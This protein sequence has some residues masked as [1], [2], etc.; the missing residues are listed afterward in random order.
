MYADDTF[1]NFITQSKILYVLFAVIMLVMLGSTGMA[2]AQ[3]EG[4][5]TIQTYDHHCTGAFLKSSAISYALI[6]DDKPYH[7]YFNST[8][9][10]ECESCKIIVIDFPDYESYNNLSPAL[11]ERTEV[12]GVGDFQ[13]FAL[14]PYDV[15]WVT[16]EHAQKPMAGEPG[17]YSQLDVILNN[18]VRNVMGNLDNDSIPA[19]YDHAHPDDLVGV[20]INTYEPARVQEYLEQN[21]AVSLSATASLDEPTRMEAFVPVSL[22][23]SFVEQ[24]PDVDVSAMMDRHAIIHTGDWYYDLD[25]RSVWRTDVDR[26]NWYTVRGGNVGVIDTGADS[27]LA[28]DELS[29]D[30]QDRC[31]YSNGLDP[32]DEKPCEGN[33]GSRTVEILADSNPRIK[34]YVVETNPPHIDSTV[35]WMFDKGV[36]TIHI[37]TDTDTLTVT[38]S[39]AYLLSPPES[40]PPSN[41][42]PIL[43]ID[44][45][46]ISQGDRVRHWFSVQD[47]DLDDRLFF[48]AKSSNRSIASI[49]GQS[50]LVADQPPYYNNVIRSGY[51]DIAPHST[52]MTKITI[53]VSDGAS[54]VTDTFNVIVTNNTSPELKIDRLRFDLM[55]GE[56][57]DFTPVAVDPDGNTLSYEVVEPAGGFGFVSVSMSNDTVTLTPIAEGQGQIEITASDGKGGYDQGSFRVCVVES[58][59]P[60]QLSPM[61]SRIAV[62]VGAETIAI[63]VIA[64]DTDGDKV[65]FHTVTGYNRTVANI[66]F[67]YLGHGLVTGEYHHSPPCNA[68]YGVE[69]HHHTPLFITPNAV[70]STTVTISTSDTRSGD[71]VTFQVIVY[72]PADSNDYLWDYRIPRDIFPYHNGVP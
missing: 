50:G 42:E 33:V 49:Y 61:P 62:P 11:L 46:I 12:F 21:G 7:V 29:A 45:A 43:D 70:G 30:I 36:D 1:L 26:P 27:T 6:P 35:N 24:H 23:I 51:V 52:G 65:I 68:R 67:P 40:P 32:P 69:Q 47:D 60:P 55:V 63:Q 18:I 44:V 56:S 53:S 57:Q 58:N 41:H 48:Y 71:S 4:F 19:P 22:L 14:A 8:R 9:I 38:I 15:F 59:S 5:S 39:R 13:T 2:S 34:L 3:N 28:G 31:H 10:P 54:V 37:L 72:E 16:N 17:C 25:T 20:I 64:T 66:E